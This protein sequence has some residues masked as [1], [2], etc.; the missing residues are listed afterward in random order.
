MSEMQATKLNKNQSAGMFKAMKM[1]LQPSEKLLEKQKVLLTHLSRNSYKTAEGKLESGKAEKIKSEQ[2]EK[3]TSFLEKLVTQ[4]KILG[5]AGKNTKEWLSKKWKLLL[6]A[7]LFLLPKSF[8]EKLSKLVN[9]FVLEVPNIIN[10]IKDGTFFEKYGKDVGETIGLAF[11]TYIAGSAFSA[12]VLPA[13]G[14]IFSTAIS[15]ILLKKTIKNTIKNSLGA[16]GA[17]AAGVGTGLVSKQI[18]Q[19]AKDLARMKGNLAGQ[20][21]LDALNRV[22]GLKPITTPIPPVPPVGMAKYS[23]LIRGLGLLGK[24]ALP[25]SVG[26]A[27]VESFSTF[28]EEGFLKGMAHFTESFTFGILKRDTVSDIF[29]SIETGIKD[30]AT[31]I[32]KGVISMMN[33]DYKKLASDLWNPVQKILDGKKKKAEEITRLKPADVS[34]HTEQKEKYEKDIAALEKKIASQT[35]KISKATGGYKTAPLT[36]TLVHDKKTLSKI[37]DQYE[38]FK[39][40]GP[41]RMV[42]SET[43]E[44]SITGMNQSSRDKAGI[45]A[46]L[47]KGG[48]DMTSGW[49]SKKNNRQAMIDRATALG[50][51]ASGKGGYRLASRLSKEE[52]NA[53]PGSKLRE[54][55][56]DKLIAMPDFGGAHVHGNAMDIR[57]PEG[58]SKSN[59]SKLKDIIVGTLPGANVVAE[60]DH[61]HIGFNPAVAP[62]SKT[63]M[64][65]ANQTL[66]NQLNGQNG[67]NTT[68][69]NAPNNSVNHNGGGGSTTIAQNPNSIVVDEK[70]QLTSP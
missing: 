57:Y 50:G 47:F 51:D 21:R 48:V 32:T 37:Q 2:E 41:L 29:D 22:R 24:V 69:V 23:G 68:I 1:A 16:A 60:K 45:V 63:D 6:A 40:G 64:V 12:I 70:Q 10:S 49:R 14:T 56:V 54:A 34:S 25:L 61:V 31:A 39:T 19:K 28:S 44:S 67:G 13:L 38:M 9:S 66:N 53:P 46:G 3:Q 8:W 18:G 5:N 15:S 62:K 33:Y 7:G 35:L 17:G 43:R 65:N 20:G 52:R 36:K 55:A 26:L 59:F 11:A 27:A 58:F 30:G 4:N 42:K